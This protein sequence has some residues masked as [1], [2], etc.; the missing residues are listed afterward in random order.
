MY[1]DA[2]VPQDTLL[3]GCPDPCGLVGGDGVWCPPPCLLAGEPNATTSQSCP[4]PCPV[5]F[6][7]QGLPDTPLI[8]CPDPCPLHAAQSDQ[9]PETLV[10]CPPPCERVGGDALVCPEP[11]PARPDSAAVCP[12]SCTWGSPDTEPWCA[13][14]EATPDQTSLVSA[15]D[16]DAVPDGVD[17]PAETTEARAASAAADLVE[18]IRNRLL[19]AVTGLRLTLFG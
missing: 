19:R 7:A 6:D 5:Y 9:T 14:A 15:S 4:D 3:T 13:Q 2:D 16:A 12:T 18:A 8:G 17:Q 1:S 10:W 11:C